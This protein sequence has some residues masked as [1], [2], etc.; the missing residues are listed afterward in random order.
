VEIELL[1]NISLFSE[2]STEERRGLFDI[3]KKRIYPRGSIVLYKG[4]VGEDIYLI[5]KGKVKVVLSHPQGKEII[6][7]TLDAGNYFGEMSVIDRLPRSATVMAMEDCEFLVIT[8]ENMT[9]QIKKNPQIALKLLS[10]MSERMRESN[11]QISSLAHFDVRGRVARALLRMLK[12]SDIPSTHGY[13]EI[14][15]PPMK[16]IA[17]RVGAS[18]ETVSRILTEFSKNKIISITRNSIVIYE[19]LVDENID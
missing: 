13:Q 14:P 1:S 11:E 5:L 6:L 9:D 2:L 19:G 4:D 15:R 12:K 17:D 7:N 16:D 8:R 3:S 18:R 10:V